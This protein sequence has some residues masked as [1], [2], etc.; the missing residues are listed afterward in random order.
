MHTCPPP[1]EAIES[2]LTDYP[3]VK[4]NYG[5]LLLEQKE[6]PALDLV[7]ALVP[8]FESAHLDARDYFC[9]QIG[10]DLHPDAGEDDKDKVE[11]LYPRCLPVSARRGLFGEVMAGMLTEQ[12]PYVGGH[13]WDIPIFLFRYHADVEKYLFDLARDADRTRQVFGRFGSDFLGLCLDRN[14]NVV[15]FIVGEA[16][17]RDNL[18]KATIDTLMLGKWVTNGKTGERTRSGK[19]VWF[20]INRDAAVPHG[21]RQLQRL[22]QERDP[23]G[24]S[25]AILSLDRVLA[26]RNPK[27]MPRTNLILIAGNDVPS[28]GEKHA[29]IPWE[30]PPEEY[31]A[32]HDLQVVEL[33]LSDGG[34]LIDKIYD[35]L[36]SED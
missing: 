6:S 10:I 26:L 3:S 13:K 30:E 16:K 25:A 35:S 24:F 11:P 19:G 7:S 18:N 20:E 8:Y 9:T 36:W 17:W 21:M 4:G 27:P 28:R 12:Y 2:W 33:I 14:G 34:E 1:G 22:L 31:T 29:L 23:D 5:H 15:R 32:P